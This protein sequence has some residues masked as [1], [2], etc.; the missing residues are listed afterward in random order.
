MTTLTMI[1]SPSAVFAT[2]A[3]LHQQQ[4]VPTINKTG[5]TA[6]A[7]TAVVSLQAP[8]NSNSNTVT[9]ASIFGTAQ[10]TLNPT[11]QSN[12]SAAAVK[13]KTNFHPMHLYH[14]KQE[15]KETNIP[16]QVKQIIIES[17]TETLRIAQNHEN[18]GINV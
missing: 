9:I 13:E 16:Q 6:T 12:T 10:N 15:A 2:A 4:T 8:A 3:Q 11:Q 5:T 14:L 1:T 18:N 7:G 17:R